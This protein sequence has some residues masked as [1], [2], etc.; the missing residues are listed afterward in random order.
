MKTRY[1]LA[2]GFAAAAALAYTTL[3]QSSELTFPTDPLESAMHCNTIGSVAIFAVD[4]DTDGPAWDLK[5]GAAAAGAKLYPS[6]DD[7]PDAISKLLDIRRQSSR[8]DK[9]IFS[10][11]GLDDFIK[12]AGH[13][14][15]EV[16][17]K[18]LQ[19]EVEEFKADME[20][21]AKF[22]N[23]YQLCQKMYAD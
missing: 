10:A 21:F 4:G 7:D 15:N 1:I 12:A 13:A 5:K 2:G 16:S 17:F 20:K 11:L 19:G 22:E 8:I 3:L 9:Q 18:Q 23:H 14:G 6:V